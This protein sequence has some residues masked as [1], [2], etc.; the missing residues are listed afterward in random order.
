[1]KLF[2][3]AR[4]FVAVERDHVQWTVKIRNASFPV[5]KGCNLYR[6]NLLSAYRTNPL[7]VREASYPSG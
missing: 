5:M 3:T 4:F 1:M 6:G 2:V 7:V